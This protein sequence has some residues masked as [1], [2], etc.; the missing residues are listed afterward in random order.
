M[1]TST[2]EINLLQSSLQWAETNQEH[3]LSK[4]FLDLVG[5][6]RAHQ[7]M[8]TYV[9]LVATAKEIQSFTTSIA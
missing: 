1:S 4:R 9:F 5:L 2:E 6:Y 3:S 7:D 8:P